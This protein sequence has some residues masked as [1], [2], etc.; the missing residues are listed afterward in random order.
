VV[1]KN[2]DQQHP[3]THDLDSRNFPVS[4]LA[5]VCGGAKAG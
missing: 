5:I 1:Q 2:Y 3:H 4:G